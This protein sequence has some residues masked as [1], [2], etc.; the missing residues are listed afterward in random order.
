MPYDVSLDWQAFH[1]QLHKQTVYFIL[2]SSLFILTFN[3][4]LTDF[5]SDEPFSLR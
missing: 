3:V 4:L 2:F 5:I 1:L